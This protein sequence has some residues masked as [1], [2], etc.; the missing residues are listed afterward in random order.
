MPTATRDGRDLP[1]RVHG[2]GPTVAFVPEA[3]V[4]PW[5]WAWVMEGLG[6]EIQTVVYKPQA[7]TAA[8]DHE[9]MVADLEA[10]LSAV[11]CRRAHLVGCGLGGQI[12]LTYAASYGRARSLLLM[13]TGECDIDVGVRQTLLGSD[14]IQSL[15]PYLGQTLDDLDVETLRTWRER[16]DPTA[17]G[18]GRQLDLIECYTPPPLHELTLPVRVRHGG[19]DRVVSPAAGESL[20]EGL[21]AGSYQVVLEA[22]HLLP[23]ATPTLVADEVIGLVETVESSS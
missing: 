12:A 1:Y 10:V 15:R 19:A 18:R 13:G 9:D 6:S 20:A 5:A 11:G 16:D 21:P 7:P 3:C 8:D 17:E 14:L 4:G 22:P 2:E 23:V